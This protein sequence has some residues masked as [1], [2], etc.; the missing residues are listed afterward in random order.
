MFENFGDVLAGTIFVV[1]VGY[2]AF[3]ID[4]KRKQLS[5]LFNVITDDDA[6]MYGQ[7]EDLVTSGV[8]VPHHR[9]AAAVA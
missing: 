4:R 1:A 9:S 2:I 3:S 7:L 6:V 8:L 5:E